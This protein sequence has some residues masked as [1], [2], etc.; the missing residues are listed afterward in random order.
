M[1]ALRDDGHRLSLRHA[2]EQ[3]RRALPISYALLERLEAVL[4][5][6]TALINAR[7]ITAADLPPLSL[8]DGPA[9]LILDISGLGGAAASAD[10][11][12]IA[13]DDGDEFAGI[14]AVCEG[15]PPVLSLKRGGATLMT[16]RPA[17][18]EP[19]SLS[20]SL[21]NV[22]ARA[23]T[24]G[25]LAPR[26]ALKSNA[27]MMLATPGASRAAQSIATTGAHY[28]ARALR[29][30]LDKILKTAPRWRTGYRM[31]AN[32]RVIDV[33][34][35]PDAGYAA[36]PDDGKRFYADPFVMLRDGQHHV[37][38]EEFPFATNKGVISHFV[39]DRDGRASAPTVVLEEP[40]HLSY[41]MLIVGGDQ[42]YMIPESSQARSIDLYR[43]DPFPH[44][45]VRERRL[46]EGVNAS[47]ATLLRHGGKLW[48]LG[49]LA[50]EGG[51]TWDGLGAFMA[52]NLFDEWRAHPANPLL[53]DSTCARPAGMVVKSAK[54][55]IR[56]TQDCSASYGG[57]MTFA[58]I[59]RLDEAGFAQTA[60]THL[61]PD[62]RWK[63][64]G[65]HTLNDDGGVEAIDWIA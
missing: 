64:I 46:V 22:L 25:R 50:E 31:I 21:D 17:I 60:L 7:R 52:D 43:A 8:P 42:I 9:D 41:P 19:H 35:W 47:D 38:V 18:E 39:I 63:A 54:G 36:L 49:T 65:A 57:A 5:R 30:R 48:L 23:F 3:M 62:P 15:R 14:A 20:R 24:L 40:H 28:V 32:D 55:L 4:M 2:P 29:Y 12:A 1:T 11:I 13:Y 58:R 45:W 33:G 6:S 56:P 53:I 51:S 27:G 44:R 37:F 59:D 61:P 26:L 10:A 34:R 16:A